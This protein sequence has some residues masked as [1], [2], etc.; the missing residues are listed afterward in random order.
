MISSELASRELED[1]ELAAD[2]L[3]G[4]KLRVC[5]YRRW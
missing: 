1:S 2:E 5:K 3:D 4:G